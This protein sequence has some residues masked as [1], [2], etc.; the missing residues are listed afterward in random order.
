VSRSYLAIKNSGDEQW[1]L[2]RSQKF[3]HVSSS[4]NMMHHK[5]KGKTA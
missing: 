2:S 1:I 5:T 4:Q 3:E